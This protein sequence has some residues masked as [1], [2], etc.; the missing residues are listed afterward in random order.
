MTD[1]QPQGPAAY[2]S[3]TV[4]GEVPH[5]RVTAALAIKPSF[6]GRRGQ[7]RTAGGRPVQSTYWLWEMET[8]QTYDMTPMLGKAIDVLEQRADQLNELRE[9]E[10]VTKVVVR[11][12]ASIE[13]GEDDIPTVYVDHRSLSRLTRLKVD[14]ELDFMLLGRED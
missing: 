7:P 10:D 14:L 4:M 2:V 11:L 12:N 9:H 6:T 8:Q 1:Q 5:D 3:V 13:P